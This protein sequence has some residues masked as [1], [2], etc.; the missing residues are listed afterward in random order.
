MFLWMLSTSYLSSDQIFSIWLPSWASRLQQVVSWNL[1]CSTNSW[2]KFF[3]G[4]PYCIGH[5]ICFS[6]TLRLV[7]NWLNGVPKLSFQLIMKSMMQEV[8][9]LSSCRDL[10]TSCRSRYFLFH[11]VSKILLLI[12][13]AFENVKQLFIKE[14]H[15][16]FIKSYPKWNKIMCKISS[17]DA[18]IRS[19]LD[20]FN[21][22]IPLWLILIDI[23]LLPSTDLCFNSHP[24]ANSGDGEKS[25][26]WNWSSPRCHVLSKRTGT[27]PQ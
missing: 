12:N 6:K 21:V 4:M 22:C 26:S 14:A 3:P 18:E 17:C 15:Q 16:S 13:R 24:Q 9:S 8:L 5:Q 20:M 11:Q 19:A 1:E 2:Y 23:S 7:Y 25:T 10:S 27:E